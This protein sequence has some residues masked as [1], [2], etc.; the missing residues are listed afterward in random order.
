[1][2]PRGR[3]RVCD[4]RILS[5]ILQINPNT[6]S[7]IPLISAISSHP[8]NGRRKNGCLQVGEDLVVDDASAELNPDDLD[9]C[10]LAVAVLSVDS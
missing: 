4:D 5:C 6:R 3:T 9:V 10:S 2:W 8:R 7:P 1:M